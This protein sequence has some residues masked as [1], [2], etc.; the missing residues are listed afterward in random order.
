VVAAAPDYWRPKATMA[1]AGTAKSG[2]TS[3]VE[4]KNKQ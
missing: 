3:K 1:K 2:E 4:Q